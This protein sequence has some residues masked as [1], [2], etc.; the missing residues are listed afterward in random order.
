MGLLTGCTTTIYLAAELCQAPGTWREH[1][2]QEKSTCMPALPSCLPSLL[3][4]PPFF[5]LVRAS[6]S[7]TISVFADIILQCLQILTKTEDQQPFRNLHQQIKTAMWTGNFQALSLVS[8][9]Q[10]TMVRLSIPMV[11]KPV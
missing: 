3:A 1:N 2:S 4:C 10:M 9:V 5:L 7:A 6:V 8:G 11:C